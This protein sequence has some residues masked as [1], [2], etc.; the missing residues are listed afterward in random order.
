MISITKLRKKETTNKGITLIA[1]VITI[2]V[3]LI[4]AGVSIA[5][6]TGGNGILNK[7]TKTKEKTN[8]EAERERL[9]LIKVSVALDN[10]GVVTVDK[11]IEQLKEE[12]II[13]GDVEDGDDDSKNIITDNGY[14]VNIAPKSDKDIIITIEGEVGKL[15]VLIKKIILIS[16]NDNIKVDV[17]VKRGEGAIYRYYYKTEKSDYQLAGE[18]TETSYVIENLEPDTYTI[19]VVATNTNGTT[20]KEEVGT[21]KQLT[22]KEVEEGKYIEIESGSN[23]IMCMV[24][25]DANS[26][27]GKDGIH[28][29]A[30]DT[31][32]Q[33]QFRFPQNSEID[34][35]DK[36]WN[37][38]LNAI[39]I[40]NDKARS[41]ANTLFCADARSIG[42]IPD[43]PYSKNTNK[44]YVGQELGD[45]N[46]IVDYNK[47]KE[48][49][50]DNLKK[51]YWLA[52][53]YSLAGIWEHASVRF[54]NSEGSLRGDVKTSHA[55]QIFYWETGS[56]HST[57][58][59][60]TGLIC[61]LRP[62][63]ILKPDVKIKGSGTSENPYYLSL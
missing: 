58:D 34:A 14:S 27:Y 10:N 32:E 38:Y 42:S 23:K 29:V 12:N 39:K 54:V 51:S 13:V 40:L 33:V 25:W 5:T 48:L 8:L 63:F 21:I 22:A 30:M 52:S 37:S 43:N 7:V 56:W 20:F 44:G 31:V 3:L 6:L 62:V 16:G 49:R 19:K 11:Y 18:T 24:L 9:E 17:Q 4:L 53:R 35:L 15:K 50:I 45:K 60:D 55:E 2:I 61:G 57:V 36:N 41:Y 1:L 59:K 46:Y 47:M 28:I 26:T